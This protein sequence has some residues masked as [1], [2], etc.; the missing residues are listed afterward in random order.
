MDQVYKD[1]GPAKGGKSKRIWLQGQMLR[2][3]GWDV[4]TTYSRSYDPETNTITLTIDQ[5]GN[6]VVSGKDNIPLIDIANQ[7]VVELSKLGD[8]VEI[9]IDDKRISICLHHHDE[10]RQ[11][12]EDAFRHASENKS[13]SM[14]TFCGGGGM[15]TLGIHEGLGMQGYHVESKWAVDRAESYLD[16]AMRNNPV[17]TSKT[18]I[19]NGSLEEIKAGDLSSVNIAQFSLPCT[20]HSKARKRAEGLEMAE[21]H[22]TDTTAIY[23]LLNQFEQINAGVYISENVVEAQNSATYVI[24]R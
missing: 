19:I 7:N 1:I 20:L 23:G 15:A 12:R 5:K 6:R 10:L 13:L 21:H 16:V 18:K 2:K 3:N 4:Q 22:P 9:T 11:Q 14:G 24:I 8:K 17:I